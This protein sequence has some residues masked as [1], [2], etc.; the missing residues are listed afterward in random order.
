[1]FHTPR[2]FIAM[3]VTVGA[4]TMFPPAQA[5]ASITGPQWTI[6]AVSSPTDL[7]PGDVSGDDAYRVTVTNTGGAANE[8]ETE[9][10]KRVV[11]P[12]T[13][14]DEL[15]E[16]LTAAPGASAEDE[17]GVI[18]AKPGANFSKDC[19]VEERKVSCTYDGVVVPDDTLV[20]VF[21]I[22]VSAGSGSVTNRVTTSGGGAPA[23]VQETQTTISSTP[24]SFGVSPGST[25]TTVSSVQAGAHSD[26]T[27]T[28]AFNTQNSEGATAGNLKDI[29][30]DLPAGFAGDLVDT[31]AC[32]G[33]LFLQASCPIATQVGIT[34]QIVELKVGVRKTELEPVYN[35]APEPGQ[36]AKIGFSVNNEYFYEGD[37]TV[38]T[39]GE[40]GAACAAS[41]ATAC[42]PYGLKTT[43]YNATSGFVDYNQFSLTIWGVPANPIH[44]PLR[45][46]PSPSG[47]TFGVSSDASEVP[48]FSNPTVC[49]APLQAE[50]HVA[51][52]QTPSAVE[53]T[54]PMTFGPIVGCDALVMEPSLTAEAT[55]DSA[56][57]PS[58]LDFDTKIPQTYENPAGYATPTLKK[59][60]VT[61]PEGMT[62]NPSSGA[63]LAA[64]SEA[65][66]AEEGTPEKTAQEK[67]GGHGCPNA[68]KLATVK[69]TTP[70]ISEEVTG[71]VYLAEPAPR[72]ETG[73]NPFNS[74]L[75]LY[76]VARASDRGVLVKAPGLVQLNET[77]GR[78]TTTF[79]GLPPLPFSLA[80]FEFNQGPTAPLVTPPACG[81]YTV[82]AQ[83]TPYSNPEGSPLAPGIPPFPISTGV[84]GGACPTGGVPPFNP[85]VVSYP[86][87][88]NAGAYSPLYLRISRNDGEQEITGFSTVFPL[89]LTANLNGVPLC[90]EGEV[91]AARAQTGAEA[92]AHSACPAASEIG[93]SIAEAGVGT[94]LAQAAGKIYLGGPY[95]GAPFSVVSVTAAHVGPFDLGTVVVHLPLDINPE[96]AIVSIP[97][98]PADQIP[99]IIKGIVIHVRN[100]R[101]YVSRERFMLN[102]TSCAPTS[103]SATVI[104]SGASFANPADAMPA[105]VTDP[106][107][108]A[109]CSILAFTPKFNV[110]VTGHASKANGA[111]LVFKIA[112]PPNAIG[113]QSWFNYAKFDIPKQLPARLNTL[114]KACL[115][116]TFETDRAACP[117]ASIIGHAVVHT[118]ILPVPLE[119]PVYFVSYGGA[120]FPDAVL[121]LKGYGITIELH[122]ETFI[123]NKTGVT[124]A[125]F[126]NLPDV[127][128]ESI[129]VTVP[130]GPY[131]EFGTNLPAKDNYSFCGQ[132]LVMP[133][134]FKAS[135][136]LEIH[137]DTPLTITGCHK[138]EK[139]HK[140]KTHH[141]TTK[142]TN[143]KHSR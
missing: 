19:V 8:E 99:H 24:A 25:T 4:V 87:H 61:L 16:G 13:I 95:E 33:S 58:G 64:C 31:P 134:A 3:F 54:P 117:K 71:S 26:L 82:T 85:Q 137:Q 12:V 62:V 126:R 106:F 141:K 73:K 52:W 20:L 49:G 129:E 86:I 60:V 70:S 109:D 22:R 115:A 94:V 27:T 122:G 105:A 10:A 67:A 143:G 139:K 130:T 57:S 84:N 121:L 79:D 142:H 125:T 53:S 77:T 83:L 92:E 90:G 14:T 42:E 76:L 34:T 116:N 123:D 37:V 108:T 51:S 136:N 72:G 113:T 56:Y 38:R 112:Y 118:Q 17:L 114:Q 133:T 119:G 81:D 128:F 39:P 5:S 88:A 11:V 7:T 93:Y 15:P 124:S 18:G 28:G 131:S 2:F 6:S 9:P 44:D 111:G 68:S 69:I 104:G 74:L 46:T 101:V 107:Q 32:S 120:K 30:D 89:G 100:I 36:V 103:L 65:Q 1:M 78:I 66:Y 138:T 41:T 110:S 43:F 132:K 75:A 48:Y 140:K 47:C 55:S 21:P 50:L 45:C 29:T 59:E 96:T 91:A 98:G 80:K 127:P 102:P 97:Q 135:N 63:G 35:L 23:A 40:G